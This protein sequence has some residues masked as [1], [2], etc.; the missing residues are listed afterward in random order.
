MASRGGNSYF[1]KSVQLVLKEPMNDMDHADG[2]S[3]EPMDGRIEGLCRVAKASLNS[4]ERKG[5]SHE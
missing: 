4:E 5:T 1:E 3:G 2:F